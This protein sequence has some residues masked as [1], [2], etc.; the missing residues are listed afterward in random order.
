MNATS[1]VE[2]VPDNESDDPG[3]KAL[4]RILMRDRL[5]G[6]VGRSTVRRREAEA[7]AMPGKTIDLYREA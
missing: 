6:I 7:A 1:T 2:A 3:T 4:A 5:G